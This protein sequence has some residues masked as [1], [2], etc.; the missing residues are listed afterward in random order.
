MIQRAVLDASAALHAALRLRHA[1]ALLD[2]LERTVVVLVPPH[3]G[4]EVAAGL[5]E[6]VARGQVSA[7]EAVSLYDS[8]LA[9]ADSCVEDSTLSR[10]A[11]AA[12]VQE[13]RPIDETLYAILA[14]RNSCPVV[15]TDR[16]LAEL[17]ERMRLTSLLP[18]D[19]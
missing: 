13:A 7:E 16:R 19:S 15:T 5:R 9:L 12:S 17:L 11:L 6:Y 2:L 10:E 3:F 4:K 18:V 14:R 1:E 8:A